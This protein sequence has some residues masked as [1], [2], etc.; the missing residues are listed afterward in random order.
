MSED[1]ANAI[2][3]ITF[4]VTLVTCVLLIATVFFFIIPTRAFWTIEHYLPRAS[5]YAGDIDRLF[6]LITFLIGFWFILCEL[7]FFYFIFRFR[8][9]PGTKAEYVT[10][11]KHEHKKWISISH[12][13]VI[14]CDIAIIAATIL[15]WIKVKQ[16][17]PPADETIRVTG[18]QWAWIFQHPGPDHQLDTDDDI[19]TVDDLHLKVGAVYHFELLSKDV[20]HS[21][22]LPVFRLKQD[23]VPGRIIKG[24]FKPTRT[25]TYDVQCAEMCGIGHG[26]MV[27]SMTVESEEAHNKW[28]TPEPEPV[29]PSEDSF[30]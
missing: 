14:L 10:G 21:F 18:Q 1:R 23:A 5:S 26:L 30:E 9:K 16:T 12:T 19:T 4:F 11:E 8:R 29:A 7:V 13:L 28:M 27:A 17:L 2:S 3:K 6:N 25:G 20:L 24:W 15:V 22:S